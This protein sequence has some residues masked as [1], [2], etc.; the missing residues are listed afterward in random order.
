MSDVKLEELVQTYLTIRNER[1]TL[2][3]AFEVKDD[4]L[5]GDLEKLE[6]AM[7]SYCNDINADSIRT[8]SGTVIKSIKETFICNDWDNF[9][10]YILDNQ[11]LDLLQQ[12]IS[13]SNLKE[14]LSTRQSE[15]LPPGISTMREVKVTVRKPSSRAAT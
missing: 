5:K 8:G 7:L 6:Q 3:H 10:S 2:K 4:E 12:R 14:F 1:N 13:D 9:K 15:G 11:A